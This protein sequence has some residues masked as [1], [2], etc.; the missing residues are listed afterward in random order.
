MVT[1][2]PPPAPK[3]FLQLG[4]FTSR[5]SAESLRARLSPV[6]EPSKVL[7][8]DNLWRLQ[9]GPYRSQDD[10][11]SAAERLERMFSLKPLLVVR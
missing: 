2:T 11:R 7:V 8:L 4:A 3:V 5:D 6:E 9:L 10:A 1:S